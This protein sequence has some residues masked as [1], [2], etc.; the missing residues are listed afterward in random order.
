MRKDESGGGLVEYAWILVLIALVVVSALTTLGS[1]I[2]T[3]MTS[4]VNGL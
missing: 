1:G 3:M 4:V 2:T